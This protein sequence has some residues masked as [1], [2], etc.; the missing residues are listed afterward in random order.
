MHELGHIAD[1]VTKPWTVAADGTW[2]GD[3]TN[4]WGPTTGEWGHMAFN[5]AIATHYGSIAFWWDNATTPTTCLSASTCYTA[6][7]PS[8]NT[9]IEASSY[10]FNTNNCSYAAAAPES[11]WPLSVMR[12]LWDVYDSHNDADGDDYSASVTDFW[13]HLSNTSYYPDGLETNQIN[14]PWSVGAGGQWVL[15]EKDGRGAVSSQANY[16]SVHSTELLRA[17]NCW[18]N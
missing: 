15:T 14:E 12:Y 3:A 2:N 7:A 1:Y 10:P 4:S 13:R 18:P 8:A 9:N 11:R 5:E 6:G 16:A 17:D